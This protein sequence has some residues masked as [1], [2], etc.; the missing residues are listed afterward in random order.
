M[1]SFAHQSSLLPLSLLLSLTL[2]ACGGSSGSSNPA[3]TYSLSGQLSIATGIVTDSDIN[4]I[5]APYASN[6]DPTNPQL[7]SNLTTVQG[8]ASARPTDAAV[9]EDS[10]SERYAN[11]ADRDDYFKASLQAGQII[12]LQVVDLTYFYSGEG[13]HGD[14][15]L[16]LAEA[17]PNAEGDYLLADASQLGPV[18]G[19]AGAFEEVTVPADG[20]YLINVYAYSGISKYVL[21]ILP[22]SASASANR[23]DDFVADE[24]IVKAKAGSSIS[25][26]ARNA[27]L[28]TV[29]SPVALSQL[30]AASANDPDKPQ[31][32]SLN[33]SSARLSAGSAE[34]DLLRAFSEALYNKRQTLMDIKR[35]RQQEGIEYAEPNYI[36][37]AQATANDPYYRYQWHYPAINLPQTWNLNKGDGVIV[38]V[39]DTGVYLAHPDL[40]GQLI[41]G[42][43]FIA[44]RDSARDGNGIDNNPDD[45]GDSDIPGASSWHGTHVAGT[46]AAASNNGIG[47]AGVAWNA[48]IMPL[49]ALGKNDGTS[50]DIIQAVRYAARLS[51]D[52]NTLP[53]Q[54]ADVINLSLGGS[55]SSAAEQAVYAAARNAGV[56]IVA[57]AGNEATSSPS[58]P[59]AYPEVISVSATRYT[60]TLAS[61]SNYG[62]T[63]SVAAP[64][65]EL[66]NDDNSDGQKDGVLSTVAD[67]SSG[68]RQPSYRLFEGT[69]MAS[70]H[71]AGVIAL[72]KSAYPALSASDVDQLLQSC[73]ITNKATSCNRDNQLGY[74][75]IDAYRAV[76]E[77]LKLA[78]GGTLPLRP[79][80]LQSSPA[81]LVFGSDNSLSFTLSNAGDLQ[82]GQLTISDDADWL[83]ITAVSVDDK[84]LGAYSASVSRSGL[85]DG[86]YN[87]TIS[88]S[89]GSNSLSIPVYMQNGVISSNNAM[90]QQY[91]LLEDADCI[92]AGRDEKECTTSI[93]AQAN[94]RYSFPAVPAGRYS[95]LAGSDIDVDNVICQAG[96]TCGAYPSLGAQQIIEISASRSGV[97]F[98]I[99]L[100]SNLGSNSQS[101]AHTLQRQQPVVSGEAG[102]SSAP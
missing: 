95:L 52:S 102:K 54:K 63:I 4:D 84:N 15:D 79:V 71:V 90:T 6:D 57:A 80:A 97:N 39:I 26:Q 59:A 17:T 36:R 66:S 48:K 89:D 40:S 46:I 2:S 19:A 41:A 81:E 73:A 3:A 85:S 60:G 22:A 30:N 70:P 87:A 25:A 67:D 75:Q 12:R 45:P 74:G 44:N 23:M 24:I 20:D 77:A 14:L 34:P 29:L 65:G 86:Y 100:N 92:A 28:N 8:F 98:L 7:L 82:P 94:G 47:G 1:I 33:R 37:K 38:A 51:N 31:L 68:S 64:G 55:S 27:G 18:D 93:F 83:S 96:E 69:S 50:Y 72:M 88:V 62:S 61:Y 78:G 42:Y 35:L 16:F 101:T 56:I 13:Y 11:S 49:R 43:D 58:Y 10:E 5:Y 21:Q 32:L 53:A 99:N 76:S 9:S 91:V